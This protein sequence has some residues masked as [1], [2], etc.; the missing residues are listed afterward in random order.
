M[1]RIPVPR[2]PRRAGACVDGGAP[3]PGVRFAGGAGAEVREDPVDH[4]GLGDEGDQAH[5]ALTRRAFQG[6]DLEDLL[7]ERCHAAGDQ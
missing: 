3:L 6:I 4:G 1:G 5:R 7:Q 2:E